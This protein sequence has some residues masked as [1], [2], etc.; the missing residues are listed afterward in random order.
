MLSGDGADCVAHGVSNG[1]MGLY[2]KP[3]C[4]GSRNS[5]GGFSLADVNAEEESVSLI[6][7]Q[8]LTLTPKY[9]VELGSN[10]TSP[11]FKRCTAFYDACSIFSSNRL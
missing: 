9:C 3:I 7:T 4:S 1:A 8:C 10:L 6:Q 5:T 2:C 11:N